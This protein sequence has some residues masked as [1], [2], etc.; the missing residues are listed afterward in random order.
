[1]SYEVQPKDSLKKWE[2]GYLLSYPDENSFK[3]EQENV[4]YA[5]IFKGTDS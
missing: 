3:A 4:E 2:R 1:M 5:S